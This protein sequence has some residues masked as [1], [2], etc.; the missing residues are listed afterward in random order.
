[1]TKPAPTSPPAP[2]GSIGSIIGGVV[3]MVLV[4]GI[5]GPVLLIDELVPE[6]VVIGPI[7]ALEHIPQARPHDAFQ[8]KLAG[9][10]F[11]VPEQ[12]WR[13]LAASDTIAVRRSGVLD[14]VRVVAVRRSAD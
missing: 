14:N 2:R 9:K 13:Q 3:A 8:V 6:R 1:M 5:A 11:A 4:I 7:E 10:Q 12:L